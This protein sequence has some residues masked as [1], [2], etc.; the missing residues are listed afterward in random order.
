[1]LAAASAAAAAPTSTASTDTSAYAASGDAMLFLALALAG[2]SAGLAEVAER[3]TRRSCAPT[4]YSATASAPTA[5]T[6]V[7]SPGV[8]TL[9]SVRRRGG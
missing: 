9:G 4:K 6:A 5:A 8:F 3:G 1:M 2:G 7:A